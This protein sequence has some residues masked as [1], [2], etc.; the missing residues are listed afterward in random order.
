MPFAYQAVG[1]SYFLDRKGSTEVHAPASSC[2]PCPGSPLTVDRLRVG[3]IYDV[4]LPC[5]LGYHIERIIGQTVIRRGFSLIIWDFPLLLWWQLH[6]PV[7][8]IPSD[9]L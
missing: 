4:I 6:T 3:I 1:A 2:L 7:I 8:G 9:V 5:M